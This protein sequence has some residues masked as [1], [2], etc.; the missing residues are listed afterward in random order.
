M[1]DKKAARIFM[2]RVRDVVNREWNPIGVPDLPE[3]EYD[4]YIGAIASMIQNRSSDEVFLKYMKMVE[5][6]EMGLNQFNRDNALKVIAKFR[7]I[8]PVQ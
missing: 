5:L 7:T 1:I 2:G 4:A 3:D 8:E 6:E